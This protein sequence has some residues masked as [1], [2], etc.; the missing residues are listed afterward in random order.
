MNESPDISSPCDSPAIHL[1][2]PASTPSS[3]SVPSSPIEFPPTIPPSALSI[4][5]V[6]DLIEVGQT[7]S[8]LSFHAFQFC[9]QHSF[10]LLRHCLDTPAE[11]ADTLF[12]GSSEMA[13]TLRNVHT[14]VDAAEVIAMTSILLAYSAATIGLSAADVTLQIGGIQRSENSIWQ[15]IRTALPSV[16][17]SEYTPFIQRIAEM[18]LAFVA[19]IRE[20]HPARLRQILVAYALLQQANRSPQIALSVN[21]SSTFVIPPDLVRCMGFA[22]AAYGHLAVNFLEFIPRGIYQSDVLPLLVP[23]VTQ[24]DIVSQAELVNP[25][26]TAYIL[27]WDHRDHH[28]VL[29]V[30][31]SMNLNDVITDLTCHSVDCSGLFP[32]L[33]PPSPTSAD[34]ECIPEQD[35]ECLAHEGFLRAACAL[36]QLLRE[37]VLECLQTH[38]NYS[39]LLCGHSLGAGVA[40]LLALI[41]S[42][43]FHGVRSVPLIPPSALSSAHHLTAL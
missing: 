18:V 10:R 24:A 20:I 2:Y 32:H 29:S 4:G 19:P 17:Y 16:R 9:T 25:F 37:V 7:G 15:Q 33:S 12:G 38:P 5:F 26:C 41:W 27:I 42:Q 11:L 1:Q 34:E 43:Q 23:G 36:D 21:R 40:S 28:L 31:G 14:T 35:L 13:E 3:S 30:R 8:N 39:I 22:A 6:R